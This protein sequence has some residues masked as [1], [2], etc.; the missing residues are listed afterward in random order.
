M[1]KRWR[2]A[3]NNRLVTWASILGIG[4]LPCPDCGLPLAVKV[5]PVA[6]AV[7]LFRRFRQQNER[8]LD[9]LLTAG[10]R[11]QVTPH[12]AGTETGMASATGD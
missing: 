4:L 9:L 5:W 2:L 6:G 10:L 12:P 8:D 7:W 11:E 3:F 1:L